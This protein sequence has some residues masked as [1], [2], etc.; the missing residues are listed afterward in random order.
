MFI[1]EEMKSLDETFRFLMRLDKSRKVLGTVV[2]TEAHPREFVYILI[3]KKTEKDPLDYPAMH[4][5]L[6]ELQKLMKKDRY[7][8]MGI[9]AFVDKNDCDVMGKVET[10][11]RYSY[12]LAELWICYPPE[13]KHLMPQSSSVRHST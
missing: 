8:Y 4:R 7:E 10:M 6:K 11:F 1:T 13:L 9:Q 5:A 2:R 12:I 3:C